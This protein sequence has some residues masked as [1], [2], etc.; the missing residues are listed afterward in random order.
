MGTGARLDRANTLA[1]SISPERRIRS[2]S[3]A[4]TRSLVMTAR[5]TAASLSAGIRRSTSAVLPEPDRS[6]DADARRGAPV[7][8][9]FANAAH[10]SMYRREQR[11]PGRRIAHQ[12][13]AVGPHLEGL[14]VDLDV[15]HRG[16]LRIMCDLRSAR[17]FLI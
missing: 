10:R 5:S 2:A 7:V 1:G 17:T 15:R 4:V 9:S 14:R 6:A 8:G 13:S 16:K 11:N 12:Q 3:S